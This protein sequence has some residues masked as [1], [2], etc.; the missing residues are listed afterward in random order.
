MYFFTKHI[1]F[2]FYSVPAGQYK[3]SC[4]VCDANFWCGLRF[5]E[6][7]SFL[8]KFFDSGRWNRTLK[9]TEEA[10]IAQTA[11][12]SPPAPATIISREISVIFFTISRF[13]DFMIVCFVFSL[14]FIRY[15]RTRMFATNTSII[16]LEINQYFTVVTTP[17][18]NPCFGCA[19]CTPR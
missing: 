19:G 11:L 2:M 17:I 9:R 18:W 13:H 5:H 6:K 4:A 10:P 8:K 16:N 7:S 12:Y 14:H 3:F 15:T 1:L